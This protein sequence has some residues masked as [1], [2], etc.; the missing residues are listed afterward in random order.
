MSSY[1]AVPSAE[2]EDRDGS[3]E[4]EKQVRLPP[5]SF[6]LPASIVLFSISLLNLFIAKKF[7][8]PTNE[9]CTSQ[10]SVWSPAFEAVDYVKYDFKNDF[11]QD[12]LYMGPPT[13]EL[14]QRWNELIPCE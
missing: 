13:M 5:S 14:E 1:R 12:G 3:F 11:G 8:R 2:G 7:Y 4:Q 9:I 10:T 6:A